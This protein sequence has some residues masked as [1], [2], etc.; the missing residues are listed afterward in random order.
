M[1]FNVG[2]Y[3]YNEEQANTQDYYNI[4]TRGLVMH[5]DASA[6]SSYPGSGTTWSDISGQTNNGTLTNGPTFSTDGGGTIVFDGTNDYASINHN[7]I[8]N[9]TTG[10]S[11]ASWYKTT[12]GVDSYITTKTNDSFYLCVGPT[13]TTANKMSF[14]LNGTSGGWLQ[15]SANANSGNWTYVVATWSG[16][17][18]S[19]YLNGVL[20][21]SGTRS[22]TLQTGTAALYLGYR[23][24]GAGSYLNGSLGNF[25]LYN[26]A[27]AAAEVL[28][29]YNIQ[30]TRFGV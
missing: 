10:L 28:Q 1:P 6:P 5:L 18:S 4:I 11:I 21:N 22:G 27:L 29:N 30:R 7:S 19:I 16:G 17:T 2:G 12:V 24:D 8:L 14:F 15:S 9:F 3:I 20:D 26:R 23:S 13:G 25:Q